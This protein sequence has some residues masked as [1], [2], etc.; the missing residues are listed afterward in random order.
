[1]EGDKTVQ[2]ANQWQTND[3][4]GDFFFFFLMLTNHQN[5]LKKN[6]KVYNIV[7]DQFDPLLQMKSLSSSQIPAKFYLQQSASSKWHTS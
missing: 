5:S 6:E 3:I 7:T 4:T 1:M 2:P